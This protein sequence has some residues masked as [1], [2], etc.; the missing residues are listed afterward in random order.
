MSLSF[1]RVTGYDA[2]RA[3]AL[4]V[5]EKGVSQAN[6]ERGIHDGYDSD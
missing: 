5:F 1:L 2:I 4:T 3:I 6:A